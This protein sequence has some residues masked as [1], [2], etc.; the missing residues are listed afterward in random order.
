[1]LELY[2]LKMTQLGPEL[3]DVT[4]V[5]IEREPY[6]TWCTLRLSARGELV[7]FSR[8]NG[9]VQVFDSQLQA[10]CT[11]KHAFDTERSLLDMDQ[12]YLDN[13]DGAVA[14]MAIVAANLAS[15]KDFCLVLHYD[16]RLLLFG[17]NPRATAVRWSVLSCLQLRAHGFDMVTCMSTTLSSV[18][19]YGRGQGTARQV[20]FRLAETTA[21]LVEQAP[22]ESRP[23]APLMMCQQHPSENRQ[24]GV[25]VNG[26][27]VLQSPRETKCIAQAD[28]HGL[29]P[30]LHSHPLEELQDEALNDGI[31]AARWLGQHV[32]IAFATGRS[33][34]VDPTADPLVDVNAG[35]PDLPGYFVAPL[36]TGSVSVQDSV[37]LQCAVAMTAQ[38]VVTAH[39][40][41]ADKLGWL[42][43]FASRV[44]P[45][46]WLVTKP[47]RSI[48][49][50]YVLAALQSTTPE[51]HVR[52]L[53]ARKQYSE[54]LRASR[55]HGLNP[56]RVYQLQWTNAEVATVA[57][58]QDWLHPIGDKTWVAQQV[59]T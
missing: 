12:G 19:V 4:S 35:N 22:A 3:V 30:M 6:M 8:S 50:T 56:D 13:V 26:D 33:V 14:D 52:S 17:I 39:S 32:W 7:Y 38:H 41:T 9:H 55:L 45:S 24:L 31:V 43:S 59:S 28:L 46:P 20:T 27:I 54:A 37:P 5:M 34:V 29:R 48:A 18:T 42:S 10:V 57:A 36:V 51:L 21:G 23:H 15:A 44:L 16:G 11:A 40:D 1:M 49:T 53:L 47:S 58:V 25:T 2:Q